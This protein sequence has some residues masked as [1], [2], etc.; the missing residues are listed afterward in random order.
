[1]LKHTRVGIPTLVLI[2]GVRI[3]G[4]IRFGLTRIVSCMGA[5]HS[6]IRE[7]SLNPRMR[8]PSLQIANIKASTIDCFQRADGVGSS[9]R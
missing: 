6:R 3:I 5:W 4:M 1:M 7:G 8:I 9:P 2:V